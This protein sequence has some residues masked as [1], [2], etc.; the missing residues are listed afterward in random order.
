[1]R[2]GT[3]FQLH[4]RQFF[5]QF[6][7]VPVRLLNHLGECCNL[8]EA[9]FQST[10]SQTLNVFTIFL[11]FVCFAVENGLLCFLSTSGLYCSVQI[12]FQKNEFYFIKWIFSSSFK[13][14]FSKLCNPLSK[15][16][17]LFCSKEKC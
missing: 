4:V 10:I 8:R 1:M 5:L 16:V 17:Q 12:W 6:G 7:L 2:R 13:L 11:P 14:S 15:M 3:T 9:P